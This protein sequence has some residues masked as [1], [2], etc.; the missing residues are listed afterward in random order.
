MTLSRVI[1][2]ESERKCDGMTNVRRVAEAVIRINIRQL[3][4]G[5]IYEGK[6]GNMGYKLYNLW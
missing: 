1:L 4:A 5:I 6:L 3:F 2:V